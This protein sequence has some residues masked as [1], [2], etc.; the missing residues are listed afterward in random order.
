MGKILGVIP[1]HLESTRLARKL[2]LPICGH[3]ML[4]WVYRRARTAGCLDQLLVATDSEE[5]LNFCV[6]DN[7]PAVMT[8]AEHR[9]GSDRIF[10]VLERGLMSGNRE[11]IYVNIQGDEPMITREHIE[12]LVRPF[13]SPTTGPETQVSTLK[14]AMSVEDARDPNKVKV[15]TDKAGRALYFS[16]AMIPYQRERLTHTTH[17]KHIGLYA[18]RA[19]ALRKFHTLE[20]ST[21][22]LSER[23]EQLR[24]LEHGVDFTV[25]ETNQ[26]TIGVDTRE[27]LR[28]VEEHF[29]RTGVSLPPA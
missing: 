23:L 18:Y 16:R 12:L 20:P 25:M 19:G 15:V 14:V 11:D 13:L 6:T 21:L 4:L 7:V 28:K 29:R 2:L 3:P 24:F 8:S 17:F 9:S 26:D 1:A 10:E 27:D 5:I 22:E